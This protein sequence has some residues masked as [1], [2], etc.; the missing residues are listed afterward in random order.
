MK[1]WRSDI[2]KFHLEDFWY[3][4]NNDFFFSRYLSRHQNIYFHRSW[5][6]ELYLIF[7]SICRNNTYDDRE[8]L[9]LLYNFYSILFF[10][11]VEIGRSNSIKIYRLN[12]WISIIQY[13]RYYWWKDDH[14]F[15]KDTDSADS[16]NYQKIWLKIKYLFV[17]SLILLK[18]MKW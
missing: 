11:R 13:W 17:I 12:Q 15:D 2:E 8:D 10:H 9:S 3:R 16:L 5:Y 1:S 6:F 18:V 14:N 7:R 4:R